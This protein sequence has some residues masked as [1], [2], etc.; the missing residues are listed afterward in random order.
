M[1]CVATKIQHYNLNF[2]QENSDKFDISGSFVP[3]CSAF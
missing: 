1:F 2:K 3:E